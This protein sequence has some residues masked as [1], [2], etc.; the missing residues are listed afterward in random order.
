MDEGS[1]PRENLSLMIHN[2][3]KRQTFMTPAEFEPAIAASE[4]LQTQ[5]LDRSTAGI[6]KYSVLIMKIYSNI[7]QLI[8]YNVKLPNFL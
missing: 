2:S 6:W 4:L 3:Q 7:M 5:A 8:S 1:A